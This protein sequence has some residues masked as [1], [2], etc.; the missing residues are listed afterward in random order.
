MLI[1]YFKIGDAI[2]AMKEKTS[3]WNHSVY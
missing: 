3:E 2:Y 1:Q